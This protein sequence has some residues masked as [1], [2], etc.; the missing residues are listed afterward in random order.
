MSDFFCHMRWIL[1]VLLLAVP[2]SV[3]CGVAEDVR[4]K[5]SS[6]E[7]VFEKD[8]SISFTLAK[9][10]FDLSRNQKP[11]SLQLMASVQLVKVYLESYQ[12]HD[13][14]RL[15]ESAILL[16]QDA[17]N[18]RYRLILLTYQAKIALRRGLYEEVIKHCQSNLSEMASDQG[19]TKWEYENLV[20][21]FNAY[22]HNGQLDS[23]R[24]HYNTRLQM[25]ETHGNNYWKARNSLDYGTFLL[26]RREWNKATQEF[27]N[28]LKI[29]SNQHPILKSRLRNGKAISMLGQYNDSIKTP[30]PNDSF[31]LTSRDIFRYTAKY[32]TSSGRIKDAAISLNHLANIALL[33]NQADTALSLN[34]RA[35]KHF[36]SCDDLGR[37]ASINNNLA[38]IFEN[39]KALDSAELYYTQAYEV[40]MEIESWPVAKTA[41][42]NLAYVLEAKGNLEDA[43]FYQRESQWIQAKKVFNEEREKAVQKYR[44]L[45]EAEENK[46]V[47]QEA[48][49]ENQKTENQRNLILAISIA[50][51]IVLI[52][53]ILLLRNYYFSLKDKKRIHQLEM[54]ELVKKKDEQR[55]GALLEG[56]DTERKKIARD[57]HDELGGTLSMIQMHL[58]GISEK[59]DDFKGQEKKQYDR[60]NT[61]LEK[62]LEQVRNIARDMMSGTISKFGLQAAFHDLADAIN[63]SNQL[64]FKLIGQEIKKP[65]KSSTELSIFRVVQ[66]LTSNTLKYAQA[67]EIRLEL[68]EHDDELSLTYE[69]DGIGFNLLEAETGSGLGLN[70]IKS[71]VAQMN[72]SVN[73]ETSSGKGVLFIIEIPFE[74]HD[75]SSTS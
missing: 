28:G 56:Q 8:L 60:A 53:S 46:R 15:I 50:L 18:K 6:S 33:I 4:Q 45:Y 62:A 69:D 68:I 31:L 63:S 65:L 22:K 52:A 30:D 16:S 44:V 11:D 20:L 34:K 38:Q 26:K 43:L 67:K 19:M 42:E 10:A 37:L 70:N 36:I 64:A 1:G 24:L 73:I 35:R 54:E 74:S 57:L 55:E 75:Q 2:A 29:T 49:I 58:S 61:L 21:L 72:G 48:L 3:W 25:A 13:A 41:A 47:A 66:E 32:F 71:R 40:A 59:V 17:L 7:S 27:V 12:Y 51:S 5:I 39:Q 23:A 14:N 9:E